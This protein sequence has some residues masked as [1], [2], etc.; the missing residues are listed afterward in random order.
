MN[1]FN[2]DPAPSSP[3]DR[4]LADRRLGVGLLALGALALVAA[5]NG[6]LSAFLVL[7]AISAAFLYA[8]KR[9][10]L[11]GFAVPAGIFAGI[12]AGALLEGLVPLEGIFL[13][14]FAGGF[15]LVRHL[16]PRRHAWSLYPAWL[17]AGIAVLV[18]VSE[19]A[20]L[21]ALLLVVAGLMLLRRQERALEVHP[22]VNAPQP[23]SP[24]ERLQRW[25]AGVAADQR[26]PEA[27]VLR[28]EQ[29]ERLAKLRPENVDAMF[30]ILD[31]AQVERYGK[32]LLEVLRA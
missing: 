10:G 11:H 18:I 3:V 5:V 9:S 20:W 21:I 16:E 27:E 1:T 15:W 14:G 6:A 23:L 7:G 19:N 29:L 8:H 25:R 24:L 2:V 31:T 22:V 30:G 12:A 13:V 4:T 28:T 17:F 32:D 26:Q